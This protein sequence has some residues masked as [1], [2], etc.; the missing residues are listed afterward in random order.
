MESFENGADL[1]PES[2]KATSELLRSF[3]GPRSR[4]GLLKVAALGAGG[5][6]IGASTILS[7]APAL[8]SGLTKTKSNTSIGDI[9]SIAATAEAL[10]VTMYTNAIKNLH[11]LGITDSGDQKYLKAAVVEEQIHY[12]FLYANGGRPLTTTFSMPHG[13]NT[14]TRMGLFIDTLEELESDF[15][16]AYLAAVKEFAEQGQPGLAQIAAQIMGIE[17]E[18]RVL[19]RDI[20][21]LTPAD[22]LAYE[23]ANLA[24]VSDAVGALS[25]QGY[26]SPS[27][28]NTFKYAAAATTYPGV[29]HLH[30]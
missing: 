13:P 9:L 29:H 14:F 10:A 25:S 19:G 20:A 6:A 15:I 27:G 2:A 21:G 11:A 1:S 17:A 23:A 3:N 18:H 12:N 26:L 7:A 28:A 5:M 8:A 30:P 4:R 24:R 22:D 16:A